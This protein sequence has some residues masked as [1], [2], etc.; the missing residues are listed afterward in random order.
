MRVEYRRLLDQA[1]MTSSCSDTWARICCE[2]G[3]LA[4]E[5]GCY[6]IGA[7]LVNVSDELLCSAKNQVF[8]N[9]FHS[10]AH[11]E[12]LL[13]DQLE[14]DYPLQNR[15]SLTLFVS[16]EPCLMCYGRILYSGVKRVRYLARDRVGGFTD[17]ARFLPPV[18]R[19]LAKSVS[20]ESAAVNP[21]WV[22]LA[23]SMVSELQNPVA[24]RQRVTEAW[25]GE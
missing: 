25:R 18:W 16:L 13:L 17:H 6:G 2:Q 1:P 21:Y 19:D 24:M 15:E 22:K 20:I 3:L 4:I 8:R 7:V 5:D 12:M 23:E 11:A 14:Q 9:G 10:H